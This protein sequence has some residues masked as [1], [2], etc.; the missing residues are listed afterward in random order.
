M[1]RVGLDYKKRQCSCNRYGVIYVHE[2][3]LLKS[4]ESKTMYNYK[5]TDDNTERED[6]EGKEN[7]AKNN[8]DFPS[9]I[10]QDNETKDEDFRAAANIEK[11]R[12][13]SVRQVNLNVIKVQKYQIIQFQL[14]E[15]GKEC[16]AKIL[17][18]VRKA[19][20]K[21]KNW[22]NIKYIKAKDIN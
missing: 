16:K 11:N 15:I 13:A 21:T 5:T 14:A 17:E 19:F 12:S 6:N 7:D 2:S 10:H 1:E 3:S 9:D 22:Y 8:D 4:L 20:T 18:Q